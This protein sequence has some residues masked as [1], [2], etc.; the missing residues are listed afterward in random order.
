MRRLVSVAAPELD[1]LDPKVYA[2][3]ALSVGI[4]SNGVPGTHRSG[5]TPVG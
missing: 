1:E 5:K 3:G 4:R 2:L